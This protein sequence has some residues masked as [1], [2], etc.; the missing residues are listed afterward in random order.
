[1][2]EDTVL[3]IGAHPV[4]L[5]LQVAVVVAVVSTLDQVQRFHR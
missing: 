4:E 1:M 3:D 2:A 5:Q